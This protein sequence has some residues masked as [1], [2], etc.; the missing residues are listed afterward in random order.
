MITMSVVRPKKN[1]GQHFLR[2]QNIARKIV[3]SLDLSGNVN[4]LEIGPGMGVLTNFLAKIPSIQLSLIEIDKESVEYLRENL[5]DPEIRIIEGD[6]LKLDLASQIDFPFSVIGNFPYNISSQIFF[7]ILEYRQY[8]PQVVG[9][10]QKEVADRY[11]AS[12]GSK[13]YGILSVLLQTFYNIEYLFTV[14]EQVF[15]PPPKVK[16]AVVRLIR[17]DRDMPAD[18]SVLL[19]FIVKA[20]FNQ[21]RKILGNA[22]KSAGITAP[23]D[24]AGKRAEQLSVD[25][26][27]S[28]VRYVK[29]IKTQDV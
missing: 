6:F 20:A 4:V 17:N 16:S 11:C 21:R 12:P 27:L 19:Q 8:V 3:E 24:L 23:P 25:Q 7:K 10:V 9:M 28:I 15:F 13:T 1:L 22:L 26:F 18:E 14:N 2:D 5:N 29:S